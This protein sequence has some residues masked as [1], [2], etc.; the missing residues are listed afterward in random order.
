[1][2]VRNVW[3]KQNAFAILNVFN[4][5]CTNSPSSTKQGVVIIVCLGQNRLP[6]LTYTARHCCSGSPKLV[7]C[8]PLTLLSTSC[9]CVCCLLCLVGIVCPRTIRTVPYI[10]YSRV[11]TYQARTLVLGT[12]IS[13]R[14]FVIAYL[15]DEIFI[16]R[17]QRAGPFLQEG[18]FLV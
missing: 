1:M 13:R 8:L 3:Y 5:L 16:A 17:P 15:S 14:F 10:S 6:L 7:L 4:G 12:S 9:R 11:R 18:Y 2:K